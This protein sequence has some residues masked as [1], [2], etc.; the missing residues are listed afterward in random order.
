M[1]GKMKRKIRNRF[2][3]PF[4]KSFARFSRYLVHPKCNAAASFFRTMFTGLGRGPKPA[5]LAKSYSLIKCSVEVTVE[6]DGQK[7]RAMSEM[8]LINGPATL[9]IRLPFYPPT[10]DM[11]R[12]H[13]HVHLVPGT[14]PTR[15]AM[16]TV[17]PSSRPYSTRSG[18]IF[19]AATTSASPPALSPFNR[20][21]MPRRN[22]V[23]A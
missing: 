1:A 19:F 9:E 3:P 10:T 5:P 23:S 4:P 2:M 15:A 11:S 14:E 13:R 21:T 6:H 12:L 7:S 16:T 18:S 20:L 8:G 17:S 22:K